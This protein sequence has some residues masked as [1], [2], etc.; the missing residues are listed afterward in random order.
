MEDNASLPASLTCPLEES[1]V[2]INTG[3]AKPVWICQYPVPQT[4]EQKIIKRV[5][6][7]RDNNWVSLAPDN[8]QWNF[9]LLLAQKMVESVPL[10]VCLDGQKVNKV[11]KNK[12]DSNL[13][14][15]RK[16]IDRLGP[17]I[18]WITMLD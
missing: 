16:V 9:P 3:D 11:T 7:W 13:L 1:E 18:Q 15:I 6:E 17:E 5:N 2:S 14:G 12:P 8:C 4:M 10:E